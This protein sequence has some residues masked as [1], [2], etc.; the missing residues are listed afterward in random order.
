[1]ESLG[2][3]DLSQSGKEAGGKA[4]SLA[5]LLQ[6]GFKVPAGFVIYPEA[7]LD[8]V[9]SWFDKLGS[10]KVAVRSSALAEDGQKGAW[11]GQFDTYLNV[12]RKDL[13]AKIIAC[14]DSTKNDRAQAYAKAKKLE[15]GSVAVIVQAM[16]PAEVSGVAFSVHPVSKDEN[17]LIIE[18]V[19]GL[20]ESLVS[21]ALTP[22]AY[23]ID[24]RTLKVVDSELTKSQPII[25][26]SML[27]K[28]ASE[29]IKIEGLYG[30]PVDV[31]WSFAGKEL[32][33]LQARPITTLG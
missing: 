8:S 24:K 7:K 17:Q 9:D 22:D 1:M 25:T 10:D 20:A 14:R 2:I 27:R 29:I 12:T 18:A 26:E 32:Y 30:F 16:V 28:L 4:S 13:R 23:I 3:V 21:G 11:A 31:E 6:A 15:S 5:K 33:F 19:H